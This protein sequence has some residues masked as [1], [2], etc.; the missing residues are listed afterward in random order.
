[1]LCITLEDGRVLQ[2][3]FDRGRAIKFQVKSDPV[4]GG[5]QLDF[6]VPSL[7]VG[8]SVTITVAGRD[9]RVVFV[10]P[11]TGAKLR[12]GLELPD[13]CLIQYPDREHGPRKGATA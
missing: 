6:V 10:K 11:R 7:S 13:D 8:D 12:V 4:H 9:H 5:H 1:M 3:P 2:L